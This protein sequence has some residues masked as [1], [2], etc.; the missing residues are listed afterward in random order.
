MSVDLGRV[1]LVPKGAY[2]AK[3]AYTRLDI[4]TS[5]GNTYLCL[6]SNTGQAVTDATYWLLLAKAG[7]KGATG[8]TGPQGQKGDTGPTGPQGEI[9]KTGPAGPTG[10]TGSQGPAGPTGEKGADGATGPAGPQG[11]Q[12][13]QGPVG[14][15]GPAGAPST[16]AQTFQVLDTHRITNWTPA[17]CLANWPAQSIKHFKNTSSLGDVPIPSGYTSTY[18]V[19]TTTV[20]G[21]NPGYGYPQQSLE[22]TDTKRP[23]TFIRIG[24]SDTA[25][26]AW[27]LTT[28]ANGKSA[29]DLAV[30]NGYTGT[31]AEWLTSLKGA[32][33]PA[34]AAGASAKVTQYSATLL[35]CTSDS[36]YCQLHVYDF[37]TCKLAVFSMNLKTN[38]LTAGTIFAQFP[39]GSMTNMDGTGFMAN[40][41][42]VTVDTKNNALK[43]HYAS[44][45]GQ[46]VYGICVTQF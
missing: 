26:S 35:N 29:Y 23:F 14:A 1:M 30:D 36:S 27:E 21:V 10:A 7:D 22:L 15:T 25:W 38:K 34:G 45:S 24:I 12:G 41:T 13:I 5:G 32:T 44:T 33:G 16:K 9:G 31:V 20:P 39:A 43:V 17:Q 28:G 3:A 2:D 42:L 4:V 37:G 6:V 8:A 46:W 18:C 40:A 19:L 11:K